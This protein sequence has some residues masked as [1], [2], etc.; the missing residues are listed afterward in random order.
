MLLFAALFWA[1]ASA[2]SEEEQF[3]AMKR[4][5]C[6]NQNC[7]DI[8]GVSKDAEFSEIKDAF[9]T[10]SKEK[11]PDKCP[12]CKPEEMQ[13]INAAYTILS[14]PLERNTYDEVQKIKAKVDAPKENP[15]FVF[16][17]VYG[18][19]SYVTQLYQKQRYLS[20]KKTVLAMSKVK[21]WMKDKHPELMPKELDRK[22]KKA[23]KKK[24]I[25]ADDE[26]TK[27]V[28]A[29]PDYTLNA[30]I[31]EFNIPVMGWTGGEPTLQ[32]AATDVAYF[33]ITFAEWAMYNGKW[34]LSYYLGGE[35]S[36][37]DKIYF[38]LQSNDLERKCW[39]RMSW[40]QKAEILKKY[41]AGLF[42][43]MKAEEESKK[44]R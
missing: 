40:A 32:S 10:L 14:N 7:Y 27:M 35:M 37:G 42:E 12:D 9:R 3:N 4:N 43:E 44:K 5:W 1:T 15:L 39:D 24:G 11:H 28:E 33:P 29:V 26:E 23:L 38:M 31:E 34:A 6:G 25:D 17:I 18:L 16:L 30:C 41:D 36:Q 8:L 13:A 20:I 19:V 22:A 21:R 2:L